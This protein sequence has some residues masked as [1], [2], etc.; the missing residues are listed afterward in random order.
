MLEHA[1][2]ACGLVLEVKTG[3]CKGGEFTGFFVNGQSWRPD[4]DDAA[5]AQVEA[6][7]GISIG[8]GAKAVTAMA[9]GPWISPTVHYAAHSEDRQAARRAAAFTLAA[10][11]GAHLEDEKHELCQG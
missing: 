5:G 4:L 7:L 9:A 1:A 3:R 6:K 2:Q 8:W 10:Y 11:I